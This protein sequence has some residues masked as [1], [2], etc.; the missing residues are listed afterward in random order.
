MDT[1]ALVRD[2]LNEIKILDRIEH[3]IKEKK[4]WRDIED[5][6]KTIETWILK[7]NRFCQHVFLN[8]KNLHTQA[9]K[10]I[11]EL[12]KL[13]FNYFSARNE[14]DFVRKCPEL[15]EVI[16]KI[17]RII[18]KSLTDAENKV[19][20]LRSIKDVELP[21]HAYTKGL[22]DN[23]ISILNKYSTIWSRMSMIR[24]YRARKEIKNRLVTLSDSIANS[25]FVE[26]DMLVV[27]SEI[28]SQAHRL[29]QFLDKNKLL[30]TEELKHKLT[31]LLMNLKPYICEEQTMSSELDKK[32]RLLVH[33]LDQKQKEFIEIG[34]L[35]AKEIGQLEDNLKN[36]V[37]VHMKNT[38]PPNLT[39][40]SRY[41]VQGELRDTIHFTVNGPIGFD[42][43]ADQGWNR[44]AVAVL[45]PSKVFPI[46][47]IKNYTKMDVFIFGDLRIPKQSVMVVSKNYFK[48]YLSQNRVASEKFY[49]TCEK[50]GI[51]L[52]VTEQ[53]P[54]A[55][56]QML[57]KKA[58]RGGAIK[59]YGA[60]NID[61]SD[62]E[63]AKEI[64]VDVTAKTH[65]T[66]EHGVPERLG[67]YLDLVNN[68]LRNPN[69]Y[70]D[71]YFTGRSDFQVNQNRINDLS[72]FLNCVEWLDKNI[73]QAHYRRVIFGMIEKMLLTIRTFNYVLDNINS[74]IKIADTKYLNHKTYTTY[75]SMMDISK[76]WTGKLVISEQLQQFSPGIV[77]HLAIEFEK[78][79]KL[80][81]TIDKNFGKIKK[82][83]G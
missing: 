34:M 2:M 45:I 72:I 57:L 83:S 24:K 29:F 13:L 55:V 30:K 54:F 8:E 56:S 52:I 47:R 69:N 50:H 33:L 25:S 12:Q 44:M 5:I 60:K 27:V 26:K 79:K 10:D 7:S 61:D 9:L 23:I 15:H 6:T 51:S 38:I 19:E 35:R 39:L 42:G 32:V 58:G 28:N 43:F 17:L 62:R 67:S 36:A 66:S 1:D 77:N 3:I 74:R 40:K 41:S 11:T 78:T 82:I 16:S 21:T 48:S 20:H 53:E 81:L 80:L 64:D 37:F 4:Q 71:G 59:V 18:R 63:I 14:E 73:A 70:E 46:N 22:N 31:I 75:R 49:R 76:N 68:S 65:D